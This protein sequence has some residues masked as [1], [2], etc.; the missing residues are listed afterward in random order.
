MGNGETG[1]AE[2][3]LGARLELVLDG[4]CIH[5]VDEIVR[6]WTELDVNAAAGALLSQATVWTG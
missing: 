3:S 6:T 5:V 1:G 2:G 4:P